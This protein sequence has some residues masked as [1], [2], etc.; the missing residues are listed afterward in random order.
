MFQRRDR[1]I[2]LWPALFR[3]CCLLGGIM[4]LMAGA[5]D[6]VRVEKAQ[7]FFSKLGLSSHTLHY[8]NIKQDFHVK[9]LEDTIMKMRAAVLRRALEV[10]FVKPL[11]N[12]KWRS[13]H[14]M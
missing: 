2:G 4:T 1:A 12:N 10:H 9:G 14:L 11:H 8:S 3:A 7:V 5:T 13:G 6:K